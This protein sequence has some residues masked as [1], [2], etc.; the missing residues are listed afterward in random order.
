[1]SAQEPEGNVAP[2]ATPEVPVLPLDPKVTAR[3]RV[4]EFV[5]LTV[6]GILLQ[7]YRVE[8]T[9]GAVTIF[10]PSEAQDRLTDTPN[11]RLAS[12]MLGLERAVRA[13][14]QIE[15]PQEQGESITAKRDII[16]GTTGQSRSYK[17]IARRAGADFGTFLQSIF[18]TP[19]ITDARGR[20]AKEIQHVLLPQD[21]YLHQ[22]LRFGDPHEPVFYA[23]ETDFVSP[24]WSSIK[25]EWLENGG[26]AVREI[27]LDRAYWDTDGSFD[28]E[29]KLTDKIY[30]RDRVLYFPLY[31][32]TAPGIE[33]YVEITQSL[34]RKLLDGLDGK[35]KVSLEK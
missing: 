30:H 4:A 20:R 2:F 24:E 22:V 16:D 29:G 13:L 27:N 17:F 25:E 1:M 19:G 15:P 21:H 14:C 12:A 7:P 34:L 5:G 6:E 11:R 35:H 9:L 3:A 8:S 10:D 32:E 31:S 28:K 18:D 26:K 33:R 23:A